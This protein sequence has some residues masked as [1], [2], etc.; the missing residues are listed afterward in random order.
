M[1]VI[2]LYFLLTI[3]VHSHGA[4]ATTSKNDFTNEIYVAA[5]VADKSV[6]VGR[7]TGCHGTHCLRQEKN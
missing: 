2:N 6:R 4:S 5:E 1:V 3:K 7:S